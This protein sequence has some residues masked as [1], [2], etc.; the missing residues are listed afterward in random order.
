MGWEKS[1]VRWQQHH[2]CCHCFCIA[3]GGMQAL[4][5]WAV[6][7]VPSNIFIIYLFS[8]S[9]FKNSF[10]SPMASLPFFLPSFLCFVSWLSDYQASLWQFAHVPNSLGHF[11]PPVTPCPALPSCVT[12]GEASMCETVPTPALSA[13]IVFLW[14]SHGPSSASSSSVLDTGGEHLMFV[15]GQLVSLMVPQIH[16]FACTWQSFILPCGYVILHCVYM[17]HFLYPCI[18]WWKPNL[19]ACLGC[20]E[21]YCKKHWCTVIQ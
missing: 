7:L 15:W 8:F 1:C 10:L 9:Y 4:H 20:C 18:G 6:P 21:L 12:Q 2:Q 17:S 5:P 13:C 14:P 3:G 19:D 11:H 16:P